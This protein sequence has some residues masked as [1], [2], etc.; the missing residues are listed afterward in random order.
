MAPAQ[1]LS[2]VDE[3]FLRTHRGL[4]TPIVLQGLWRTSDRV[5]SDLLCQ[6]HAALR[7]GPLG[8]RVIRPR[9]PG[10][11]RSWRAN[12]RAYPLAFT[13]GTIAAGALLE[14]A[15]EQGANLDPEYG[16]GWRLSTAQLDDGGSI[17]S[18]TCSHA[19]ADGRALVLAV[20]DALGGTGLTTP[21]VRATHSPDTGSGMSSARSTVRPISTSAA[22]STPPETHGS[23]IAK[24]PPGRPSTN[25]PVTSDATAAS[26]SNH[27]GGKDRLVGTADCRNAPTE[28]PGSAYKTLPGRSNVGGSMSKSSACTEIRCNPWGNTSSEREVEA[29]YSASDWSDARRQWAIV[30]RGTFRALRR[31]IP[32]RPTRAASAREHDLSTSAR[33]SIAGRA[34]IESVPTISVVLQC[35]AADWESA[36]AA[37]GGTANSLFIALVAKVLLAS[38]FPG[39]TIDA[40]LPVD[41][42]D[43]PRVDNDLAMTEITIERT[44]TPATIRDKTRIAYERR[45]SS[46]GGMPEELLQVIPDRWAYALS[47]GAGERDILCSNIG[48]LPDSLHA[49]GPH[50]CTGVAARA[51]HPGLTAD[52]LPRTRLSGYLCRIADTYTLALVSLDPT[53]IDT[54]E[55][56]RT[57]AHKTTTTLGLPVTL[58]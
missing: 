7:V 43:E 9:V 38:G 17:V 57:L 13:D 21:S 25:G 16:P 12:T 5:D 23:G 6:V 54:P 19:L 51:I 34:G 20:D 46:P 22:K 30:V 10:A 18:L 29:R 24:D 39:E 56:L 53:R 50:R 37:Q 48:T 26:E 32:E 27:S 4:G 55:T 11:R 28:D 2:V 35:P 58:W 49:L 3:I 33:G 14:W 15:D 8:R 44:D 45:M 36:A 42:R 41:T 40:S 47:K 31:G 1:R 52:R